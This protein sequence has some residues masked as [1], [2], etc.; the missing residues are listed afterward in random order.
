MVLDHSDGFGITLENCVSSHYSQ[1]LPLLKSEK[2][3]APTLILLFNVPLLVY[4]WVVEFPSVVGIFAVDGTGA[5]SI[6]DQVQLF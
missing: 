3:S 2:F 5:K 6:A 4:C 1:R